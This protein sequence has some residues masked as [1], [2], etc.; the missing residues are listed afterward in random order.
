MKF[1]D[2]NHIQE[3]VL[4][5]DKDEAGN[6]KPDATRFRIRYFKPAHAAILSDLRNQDPFPVGTYILRALQYGLDGWDSPG[7][8]GVRAVKGVL[9]EEAIALLPY[10]RRVQ[11]ER[12]VDAFNTAAPD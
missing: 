11:L 2:P 4:D 6:P 1:L 12:A 9:G 7:A 3:H 5:D 10:P 8:P